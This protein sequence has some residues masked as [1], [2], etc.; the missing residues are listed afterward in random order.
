MSDTNKKYGFTLIELLVVV[1][2]IALL[3]SVILGALQDARVKARDRALFSGVLELQKAVELYKLKYGVYPKKSVS[4]T[5]T[6]IHRKDDGTY[7]A[8]SSAAVTTILAQ[9]REFIPDMPQP[10]IA[11]G[12]VGFYHGTVWSCPDN[13]TSPFAPYIIVF[14]PENMAQFD[15]LPSGINYIDTSSI[16]NTTTYK[17]LSGR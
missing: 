6:W 17:C 3:S 9:I 12:V 11:G 13:Q 8:G 16:T 2:I 4:S 15:N 7:D 1:S 10:T 14:A 5:N